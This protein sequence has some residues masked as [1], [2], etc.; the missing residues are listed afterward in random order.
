MERV[1]DS[2]SRLSIAA[3]NAGAFRVPQPPVPGSAHSVSARHPA[4]PTSRA[5]NGLHSQAVLDPQQVARG[6]R[7]GSHS[8]LAVIV[9]RAAQ[10]LRVAQ[11]QIVKT[12]ALDLAPASL[13][14]VVSA[15]TAND[16]PR[17]PA[18]ASALNL[19]AAPAGSR[20]FLRD[21][22]AGQHSAGLRGHQPEAGPDSLQ[23]EFRDREGPG[24]L[25][26][27][28]LGK[29]V[30]DGQVSRAPAAPA[31]ALARAEAEPAA[32]H[33]PGIIAHHVPV[34]RA[35]PPDAV[36]NPAGALVTSVRSNSGGD[37]SGVSATKRVPHPSSTWVGDHL[38]SPEN[39]RPSSVTGHPPRAS[40]KHEH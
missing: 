40:V 3:A 22:K 5:L 10:D 33:G 31:V 17:V 34:S 36:A 20:A 19:K 8:S 35:S 7:S 11:D 1:G 21:A 18:E 30:P 39:G 12:V 27:G 9:L 28:H 26:K 37:R 13:R 23:L 25:Q 2:P 14:R 29:V 24:R 32:A 6:S 16:R 4:G 15:A 38:A